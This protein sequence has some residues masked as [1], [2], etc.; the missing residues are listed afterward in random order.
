MALPSVIIVV[1]GDGGSGGGGGSF[2]LSP[3]DF[4]LHFMFCIVAFRLCLVM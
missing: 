3:L 2:L 1:C 4:S